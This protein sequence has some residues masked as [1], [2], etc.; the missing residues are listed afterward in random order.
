MI[1]LLDMYCITLALY[2]MS[3]DF[4][5]LRELILYNTLSI[6]NK[7]TSSC[8]QVV[9][10]HHNERHDQQPFFLRELQDLTVLDGDEVTLSVKLSGESG[11]MLVQGSK[12]RRTM[13]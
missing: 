1:T 11:H 5:D 9:V 12:G 10:E 8:G 3:V 2:F 4:L 7:T 6:L 13:L